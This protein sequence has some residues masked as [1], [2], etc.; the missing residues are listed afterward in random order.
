MGNPSFPSTL[1]ALE[2]QFHCFHCSFSGFKSFYQVNVVNG[3]PVMSSFS[4]LANYENKLVEPTP[5]ISQLGIGPIG[6]MAS[7]HHAAP[8]FSIKACKYSVV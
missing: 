8:I 1:S 7:V 4:V 6:V 5:L 3:C 2:F